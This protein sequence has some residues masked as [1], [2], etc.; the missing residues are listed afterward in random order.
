MLRVRTNCRQSEHTCKREVEKQRSNGLSDYLCR[1]GHADSVLL[2]ACSLAPMDSCALWLAF[3]KQRAARR[4][5]SSSTS[6]D[7]HNVPSAEPSRFL[8]PLSFFPSFSSSFTCLILFINVLFLPLPPTSFSTF[9]L[10]FLTTVAG[11]KLASSF[12]F[13]VSLFSFSRIS[14]HFQSSSLT[15]LFPIAAFRK[16]S[17]VWNET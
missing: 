7:N 17:S 8:Q 5:C 1:E 9:L 11:C 15:S 3:G 16:L 6:P 2:D 4:A 13:C 12:F 10:S 14:R